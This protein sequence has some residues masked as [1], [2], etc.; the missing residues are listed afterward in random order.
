[1]IKKR[2]F[3]CL[4]SLF[5]FTACTKQAISPTLA[6]DEIQTS[7]TVASKATAVTTIPA[8]GISTPPD[9]LTLTVPETLEANEQISVGEVISHSDIILQNADEYINTTELGKT[10]INVK[11]LYKDKLYEYPIDCNVTDTT[12]PV[13]LNSGDGAEIEVGTSFDLN[14]YVG[15]VDNYDR[16]P[17]LTYSGSIDSYT[18]GT[19]YLTATAT[20]SEGNETSWDLSL[21]VTDEITPYEDNS[22]RIPF[23]DFVSQ[24]AD[25]V[26]TFGIDVSRWQ[27]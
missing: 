4:L 3:T 1:M 6:D 10:Q 18:C 14:D 8:K 11:Y 16:T 13:L 26:V 9:D 2:F 23:E 21:T 19:Y 5:L 15:F 20:D 25:D 17:E 22:E 24:Y 7:T 27:G 12:A